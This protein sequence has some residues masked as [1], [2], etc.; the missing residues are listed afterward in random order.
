MKYLL[1]CL[2]LLGCSG[3]Q[4]PDAHVLCREL[5]AE[6]AA[7]PRLDGLCKVVGDAGAPGQ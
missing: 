4:K 1:L 6:R 3:A 7:N 5:T 2:A